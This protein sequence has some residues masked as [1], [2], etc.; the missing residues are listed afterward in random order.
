MH[1][2]AVA[3]VSADG[4]QI[5]NRAMQEATQYKGWV[6]LEAWSESKTWTLVVPW[7][8]HCALAA[9]AGSHAARISPYIMLLH[10]KLYLD[11]STSAHH[12]PPISLVLK[13]I[14]D[15]VMLF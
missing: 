11:I 14:W 1:A 12:Q 8:L 5:V 2:Q 9:T 15:W 10:L 7:P 6:M 13:E 3:G 4:R